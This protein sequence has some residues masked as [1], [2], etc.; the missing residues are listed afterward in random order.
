M[1]NLPLKPHSVDYNSVD[2]KIASLV[3]DVDLSL[4]KELQIAL[5]TLRD[6]ENIPATILSVARLV[7]GQE[8][9]LGRIAASKQSPE[10]LKGNV[11]IKQIDELQQQGVIPD[12]VASDMHWIRIRAN[13]ARHRKE[14]VCLTLSEAEKALDFALNMVQWFY[15]E[16]L[17]GCCS[18]GIYASHPLNLVTLQDHF[19]ALR[20]EFLS[21]KLDEP[22]RNRER[23]VGLRP[24]GAQNNFEDR[25]EAI[26]KI[27]LWLQ[28]P[29]IKIISISGRSGIGKTALLARICSEIEAG[30]L[31]IGPSATPIDN[32]GILYFHCTENVTHF[33][34]NLFEGF[35]CLLGSPHRE[36]LTRCYEDT[37]LDIE[38]KIILLLSKLQEGRFLLVMDNVE[39]WLSSNQ[40]FQDPTVTLFVNCCLSTSHSLLILVTSQSRLW[41]SSE[42]LKSAR[43]LSLEQ[44]LPIRES[45]SLLRALDPDG[46]L[47]LRHATEAVLAEAA[48]LTSGVPRA[49]EAIAGI[50]AQDATLSVEQLLADAALFQGQIVES[51]IAEGVR[52]LSTNHRLVLEVLAI[53]NTAVPVLAI[54]YV[55]QPLLSRSQV[56]S[57]LSALA[58]SYMVIGQRG[59]DAYTLSSLDR[60]YVYEQILV[61]GTGLDLYQGQ[62]RTVQ[63]FLSS[64]QEWIRNVRTPQEESALKWFE[65]NVDSVRRAVE[66][67]EASGEWQVGAELVSS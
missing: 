7:E 63:Y 23:I 40:T 57:A 38:S 64:A 3:P 20:Q 53:Y 65:E 55:L 46:D 15:C 56:Q 50:L 39:R 44:G 24:I 29:A 42:G 59:K 66:W 58:S 17:N 16:H 9:L 4:R 51:L 37:A 22:P 2:Y 28:D 54:D 35:G 21:K 30:K 11:L 8:G 6:A 47:G 34:D 61:S 62:L 31:P 14:R 52:R 67:A 45:V 32:I 13:I 49:L 10:R 27:R 12:T 48:H 19:D 60:Q 43:F 36:E 1:N 25:N 5:R 18:A 41:L 26:G 33:I